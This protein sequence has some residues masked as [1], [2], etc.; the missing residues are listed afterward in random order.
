MAVALLTTLAFSGAA[1]SQSPP[2]TSE[3]SDAQDTLLQATLERTGE[4]PLE[5]RLLRITLEPG[6]ASPWHAHPGLE[7]GVVESGTLLVET[8]GR[9]VLRSSTDRDDTAGE[10]PPETEV[11]LGVDDRIAYAPGTEM[12]FRNPGPGTTTM[13]VGTVLP[14]GQD[15][16]PGVV[17]R[18]GPP[19][20]EAVGGVRSQELGAALIEP[21][22][23]PGQRGAVVLERLEIVAGGRVPA[24]DGP[25]L[26]G[27]ESGGLEGEIRSGPTAT[28]GPESRIAPE[29]DG[30]SFQ[31]GP[32][33]SLYFAAG[34]VET[35]PL[36]GDGEV[37]LLRFGVV[38]VADERFPNVPRPAGESQPGEFAKGSTV[39]VAVA[40]ARLRAEPSA[41]GV[42]LAGL[43]GGQLLIVTGP[44][45]AADG[46]IWY[47]VAD[48]ADPAFAG[49]VAGE[50]LSAA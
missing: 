5:L 16:P 47:P 25:V 28:P 3:T 23:F 19:S 45:V 50:L 36:G 10:V 40:E 6:G 48:A 42:V 15:A 44:P 32:G 39:R 21:D 20:S 37:V 30:L 1:K 33:E 8:R 7:F 22:D 43:A 34:M 13:L 9:A 38:P 31:L 2:A 27:L 18:D 4:S 12:T 24:F 46:F 14:T 49:Y 35:A 41:S 17:Y 29:T 11:E 26:V